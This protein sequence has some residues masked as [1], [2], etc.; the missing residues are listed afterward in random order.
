MPLSKPRLAALI[1]SLTLLSS[2]LVSADPDP[3]WWS[4]FG[5]G[6]GNFGIMAKGM[7][8]TVFNGHL[9]VG[10]A[11]DACWNGQA[12]QDLHHIGRFNGSSWGQ[13]AD[14]FNS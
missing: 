11:F 2:Q 1:L 12:V 4:Y 3:G 8:A 10:G 14:G 9:I 6:P 7:D 13:I 5:T